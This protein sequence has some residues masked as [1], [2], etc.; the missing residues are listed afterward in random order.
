MPPNANVAEIRKAFHKLILIW[1]PD[2]GGPPGE[3]A[4]VEDAYKTLSDTG[5]RQR[6]QGSLA[7]AAFA[8]GRAVIVE[9]DLHRPKQWPKAPPVIP[10]A[11]LHVGLSLFKK[12]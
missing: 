12:N 7:R 3:F 11:P 2:K 1:H 6:Y 5:A 8:R 10:T 4:A 9:G